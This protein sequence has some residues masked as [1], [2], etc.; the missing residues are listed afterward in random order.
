MGNNR[1]SQQQW[2]ALSIP[3]I[4]IPARI[5]SGG[6]SSNL[7]HR[8][9]AINRGICFVAIINNITARIKLFF[10][11][12]IIFINYLY[13]IISYFGRFVK[14]TYINFLESQAKMPIKIKQCI[15][16]GR[17]TS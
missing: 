8:E 7:R 15:I 1:L 4:T 11:I 13:T 16:I 2:N 10:S 3:E 5:V 17:A 9:I 6:Q 12:L 14:V